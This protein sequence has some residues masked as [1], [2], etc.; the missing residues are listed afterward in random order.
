M[1]VIVASVVGGIFFYIQKSTFGGLSSNDIVANTQVN[2]T[3]LF[4]YEDKP[5][6]ISININLTD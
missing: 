5:F 2:F 3:S 1:G 4:A 6:N